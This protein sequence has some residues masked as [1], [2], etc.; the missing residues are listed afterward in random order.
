MLILSFVPEGGNGR[1]DLIQ[2]DVPLQDFQG[3]ND[4]WE[5]YHWTPWR[6]YLAGK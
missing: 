4:G 1:I 3:V 5:K 6:R 2:I